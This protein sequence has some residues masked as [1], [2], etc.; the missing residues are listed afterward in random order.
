MTYKDTIELNHIEV[1]MLDAGHIPGAAMFL[2]EKD[3]TT[4]YSGDIHTEPQR[5]VGGARPCD[6]TNLFIEG[7]YGGRMHPSRKQTEADFIAKVEEVIDR[8]GTVLI[9]C[10]A[11]GR[12]QEVMLLLRNLGYDM[13][14]DGMGRKVTN[15]FL[16][17][18]EYIRD[19]KHL[20]AAKKKFNEVRN[21]SS[22]NAACKGDIIVT[23]GGM[24]DGG[25]VLRYLNYL[26]DDPKS[27]ILL[28]G[29]QADDTN[30]KLLMDTGNVVIDGEVVKIQ[31]ELQ[32]YDFS[33]HAD[34]QQIVDF[35]KECDPDNVIIMHSESREAFLPDLTDYNV[36]LPETGKPFNLDV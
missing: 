12:T 33:A 3:V 26:K 25:P 15:L 23:T 32:K 2:F 4:L 11:T 16:D 30:G 6:C 35:I 8:G 10:F 20:K 24:L 7:T 21:P 18:P 14:V 13:W 17:Y 5:L 27:A 31:C 29:Y 19:V 36:I 1:T 34:H 22:R 28:V 9:P